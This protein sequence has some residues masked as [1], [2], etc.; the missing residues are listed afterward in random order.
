MA[1]RIDRA[2]A[3][4]LKAALACAR[5]QGAEEV[6]GEHL[7]VALSAMPSRAATTLAELGV[8]T[9]ALEAAVGRGAHDARLL[10][11]LGIDLAEVQRQVGARLTT[12]WRTRRP[13]FRTDARQAI[14]M[15]MQERQTGRSRRVGPEHL[16]LGLLSSSVAARELLLAVDVDVDELRRRLVHALADGG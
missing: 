12:R 16:L 13:G 15:S 2:V 5:R 10:A 4:A 8:D 14:S 9:G 3:L 11:G 1:R 6:G 7:L